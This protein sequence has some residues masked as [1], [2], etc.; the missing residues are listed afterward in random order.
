MLKISLL[1]TIF[2][3]LFIVE[4]NLFAQQKKDSASADKG[5]RIDMNKP[6]EDTL[7]IKGN[8]TADTSGKSLLALD[9]TKKKF[10][11]KVATFRSAVLP[12]WGQAYNKKYWKIPIIYG[13]L[14]TTGYIFFYNKTT[15][16]LLRKAVVLK[17]DTDTAND[18]QIDP[19]FRAL[20]LE[21]IRTNRNIFRQNIDYSVLFFLIF[22]GLN[23]VDATVDAHL[24]GFDVSPS[25]TMKITPGLNYLSNSAGLSLI[26]TFKDKHSKVL[27]SLP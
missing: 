21:A 9:T 17:S 6:N 27:T 19:R 1:F 8:N 3:F 12:G 24:K 7:F 18:A 20:S 14:G 5:T 25:I 11:P 13:A 10:N 22:W 2:F 23:V 15:Y 26:F 4:N 16:K